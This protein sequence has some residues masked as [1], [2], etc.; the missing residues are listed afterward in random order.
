[1]STLPLT[2]A[3]IG[4]GL[5]FIAALQILAVI[6][7]QGSVDAMKE[8]RAADLKRQ[9]KKDDATLRKQERD[10]DYAR[11]D[12]VAARVATAAQH[13]ADAASLL[14]HAQRETTIRTD[15]IAR[16]AAEAASRINDQLKSIH[17]Q[18]REI[19]T[20][21]N[22]DMTEARTNER[23]QTKLTLLALKKVQALSA[24]LGLPVEASETEAIALAEA[25]IEEL[26]TILADRLA[27]QTRVDLEQETHAALLA[28]IATNTAAT[29]ENTK[30]SDDP[31]HP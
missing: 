22:S 9:E 21:V 8:R 12:L 10:E 7:V 11:Q 13:A 30:K 23:D 29:A 6:I 18:G 4:L 26:N 24:N 19:H 31:P 14:L 15:E 17:I 25:R 27:A 1:M 2:P 5:A 28:Q 20:L 16:L 3:W